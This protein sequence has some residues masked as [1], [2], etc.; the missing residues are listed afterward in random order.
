MVIET[1]VATPTPI[2]VARLEET[3]TLESMT[4]EPT[5]PVI[6]ITL[7]RATTLVGVM[8]LEEGTMLEG[9]MTVGVLVAATRVR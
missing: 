6:A 2:E 8:I 3:A 7:G 4:E 1:V 5:T 9:A